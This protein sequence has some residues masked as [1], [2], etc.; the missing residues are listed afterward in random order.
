MR[1][2]WSH[3]SNP[4][5]SAT[6]AYRHRTAGHGY[7]PAAGMISQ[8]AAR[9]RLAQSPDTTRASVPTTAT[10]GSRR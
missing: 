3:H 6:P 10:A 5:H 1:Q 9:R 4:D 7:L 2:D 8:Q